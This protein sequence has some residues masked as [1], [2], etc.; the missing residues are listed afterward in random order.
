MIFWLIMTQSARKLRLELLDRKSIEILQSKTHAERFA[1]ICDL[2]ESARLITISGIMH[3][4]PGM[5]HEEAAKAYVA[6]VRNDL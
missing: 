5:S 6:R 2:S 1:T 4:N 3:R